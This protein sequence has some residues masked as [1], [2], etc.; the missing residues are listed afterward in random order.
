MYVCAY[1]HVCVLGLRH[2][3]IGSSFPPH[4]RREVDFYVLGCRGQLVHA[5]R[6]PRQQEDEAHACDGISVCWVCVC[7]LYVCGCVWLEGS[8]CVFYCVYECFLYHVPP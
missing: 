2:V 4:L 7:V 6:Q 3:A 5:Q 8:A 1:V